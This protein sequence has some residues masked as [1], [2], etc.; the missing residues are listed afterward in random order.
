VHGRILEL[1]LTARGRRLLRASRERA[2]A[3]E[4]ELAQGLTPGEQKIVR[5]WL[6][7]VARGGSLA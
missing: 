2:H 1:E 5:R 4:S 6:V 3:L 7:Q